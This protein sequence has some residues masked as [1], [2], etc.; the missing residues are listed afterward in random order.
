MTWIAL[1]TPERELWSPVG[2]DRP[3]GASPVLEGGADALMERGSLVLEIDPRA[4][5]TARLVLGYTAQGKWAMQLAVQVLPGGALSF[6]L[7]QNGGLLHHV[8]PAARQAHCGNL[9]LT[10]AWDAPSRAA[11][12]ALERVGRCEAQVQAFA[13]P[14]PMRVL[15]L[16]N[17]LCTG[18]NRYIAPGFCFLALSN[19]IQAVGPR[20]GLG[21]STRIE[22]PKGPRALGTFRRG[23]L[24]KTADGEVLP[25]LFPIRQTVPAAGSFAPLRLLA[26]AHG[27]TRDMAIAQTQ[28]IVLEGADVA[29]H[30]GQDRALVPA[31]FLEQVQPVCGGPVVTYAQLVLAKHAPL[32]A[33]GAAVE[34][35]YIG[36][37]RRRIDK[38]S[39]SLLAATNRDALPEHVTLGHP[40]Q[41]QHEAALFTAA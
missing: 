3:D 8:F 6:L 33:E 7:E 19:C 25:V 24:V 10:Y 29:Y 16:Q 21:L 40:V 13:N 32:L 11:F 5:R 22:T 39:V 36:R 37:L 15:D 41:R 1:S 35:L 4:E 9:R 38:L 30:L 20:P 14:R 26:P 31:S 12:V 27:L 18:A 34:S 28:S 2:L 17:L 23:D